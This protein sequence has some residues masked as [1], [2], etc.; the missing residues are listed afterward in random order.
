MR[1]FSSS[2]EMTIKENALTL[3]GENGHGFITPKITPRG[4]GGGERFFLT[5]VPICVALGICPKI[6]HY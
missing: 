5:L 1:W 4:D 3:R 2:R 6:G